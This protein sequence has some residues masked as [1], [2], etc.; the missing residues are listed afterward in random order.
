MGLRNAL[1][2]SAMGC[3]MGGAGVV[4]SSFLGAGR[5]PARSAVLGA[6]GFM[7]TI[8]GVGTFVRG[9]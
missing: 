4:V 2:A 7:G 6:A 5:A 1:F 3:F 8:F 9:R